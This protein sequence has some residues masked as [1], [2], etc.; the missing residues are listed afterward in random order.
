MSLIVPLVLFVPNLP[1]EATLFSSYLLTKKS[2]TSA[3]ESLLKS[4]SISG[5]FSSYCVIS[6]DSNKSKAPTSINLS[7]YNLCSIGSM[8][9]ILET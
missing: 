9:V 3:Q 5:I 7:K 2:N 8:S 1:I 4:R 6:P